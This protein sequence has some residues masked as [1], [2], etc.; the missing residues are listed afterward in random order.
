MFIDFLKS[1]TKRCKKLYLVGDI[2][3]YWFDYE[4]VI[5]KYFY[6]T[7]TALYDLRKS[8]PIEFVMGNHDF[9]H[10]GFFENELRIPVHSED[11]VREH[12]RRK[13]LISHGDGKD[14]DDK[15]YLF[16]KKILRSPISLALYLKLH[17]NL[18]I[19]LAS[20]SSKKSRDFTS[21][22]DYGDYD[23]MKHFAETKIYEGFDYVIMGHRHKAE[24]HTIG[25]GF[26]VN[27]GEWLRKPHYGVFDGNS[28]ELISFGELDK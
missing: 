8:V 11:I 22:K 16:I 2:F 12:S 18:G 1:L 28:F 17:P 5:P 21:K 14:P 20:G 10:S 15:N 27:L 3:D 23:T 19:K 9:G 6:R 13:F 26:Y 4:T 24:M 25:K 7:L